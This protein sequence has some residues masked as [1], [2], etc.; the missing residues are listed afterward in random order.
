M[1][2]A[3]ATYIAAIVAVIIDAITEEAIS[4]VEIVALLFILSVVMLIQTGRK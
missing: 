2:V 3:D 1:W 4:Y